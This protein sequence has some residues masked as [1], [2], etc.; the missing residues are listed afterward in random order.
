MKRQLG[1]SSAKL[2]L[3]EIVR[4]DW[5]V[6]RR[7]WTSPGFRAVAVYRFGRWQRGIRPRILRVPIGL[8]YRA[9]YRYVRNHYSI[10]L[11]DSVAVGRRLVIEHCGAI[12]VHANSVVGDDCVIRQG[13]T[14][15]NDGVGDPTAAPVLGNYVKLGAG[16]MVLGRVEIGDRAEIGANAV[17]HDDIGPGEVAVGIPARPVVRSVRERTTSRIAVWAVALQHG[18]EFA[19]ALL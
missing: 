18:M 8:L 12:Y 4:E 6:H 14:L 13:V 16:V 19:V 11:P 17:V 5:L 1:D 15:G 2:G 7:D 9:L 3:W 10:D